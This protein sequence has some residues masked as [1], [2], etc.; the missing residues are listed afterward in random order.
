MLT[1]GVTHKSL[2]ASVLD[3]PSSQYA[4]PGETCIK[5]YNCLVVLNCIDAMYAS[6]FM[7]NNNIIMLQSKLVSFISALVR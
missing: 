4:R 5:M 3:C 7:E 6:V 2:D 1:L